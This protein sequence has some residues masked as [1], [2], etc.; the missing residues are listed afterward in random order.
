MIEQSGV[1][2][3]I[4]RSPWLER[5]EVREIL[6][7]SDV[8]LY[9]SIPYGGWEEQFGYSLLEA[10]SMELPLITTESGSISEV[11]LNGKTG[12]LIRPDDY[13]ALKEAMLVL[14]N[15]KEKRISIGMAGRE[16]VKNNYSHEIIA[17]KFYEFFNSIK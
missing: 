4:F 8:F 14:A 2:D 3:L 12:I 13:L 15:D 11:V 7:C 1:K 17:T 9:P 10:S 16:F 6:N 5:N